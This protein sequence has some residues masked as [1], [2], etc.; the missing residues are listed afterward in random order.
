MDSVY[1]V[2]VKNGFIST[3]YNTERIT[4]PDS[5]TDD[6]SQTVTVVPNIIL[7]NKQLNNRW[8]E[9]DIDTLNLN[10]VFSV[11]EIKDIS[12]RKDNIST[13]VVIKGTQKNNII[14]GSLYNIDRD[15]IINS[16]STIFANYQPNKYIE[17]FVLENNVEIMRGKLLISSVNI[18][19]GIVYYNCSIIGTIYSF[20][21]N[22]N[23]FTLNELDYFSLEHRTL[24][25]DTIVDSDH[26]EFYPVIDYGGDMIS[27]YGTEVRYMGWDIDKHRWDALRPAINVNSYL[28][29]IFRGFRYDEVNKKYTQLDE[30]GLPIQLHKYSEN[31]LLRDLFQRLV[32]PN[33]DASFRKNTFGSEFSYQRKLVPGETT[34]YYTRYYSNNCLGLN[35][36]ISDINVNDKDNKGFT[37]LVANRPD[38]LF[39]TDYIN[40]GQLKFNNLKIHTAIST[41]YEMYNIIHIKGIIR[42]LNLLGDTTDLK[43]V[44]CKTTD[45]EFNTSNIVWEKQLNFFDNKAMID[46]YITIPKFEG[47]YAVALRSTKSNGKQYRANLYLAVELDPGIGANVP[48]MWDDTFTLQN[49]IPKNIKI[50][51]FLKH[52]MLLFNLYII[53]SD[54]DEQTYDFYTYPEFYKDV[55][56]LDTSTALDWSNKVD[57]SSYTINSNLELPKSYIFKYKEDSDLMNTLYKSLYNETY[58]QYNLI[59][60]AGL[61][62]PQTLESIFSPTI[63]LDWGSGRIIGMM[64]GGEGIGVGEKKQIK[65]NIRIAFVSHQTSCTPFYI[66]DDMAKIIRYEDTTV[67]VEF[68]N[69][70]YISMGRFL[71]SGGATALRTLCFGLPRQYWANDIIPFSLEDKTVYYRHFRTQIRELTD[72]NLVT[73]NLKVSLNEYDINNL[74]FRL[75]IF[76]RT[77]Y[78]S[79]YFKLLKVDYSNSNELSDVLLQKIV[80]PDT[81]LVE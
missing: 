18:K 24:N 62:D 71:P 13:D 69:Y 57:F 11:E 35:Y 7:T 75:P 23:D 39:Y 76:I 15:V 50:K 52:I 48:V 30:E 63:T 58:G 25:Y 19:S 47:D 64:C 4:A 45:G 26:M 9:L 27:K 60:S 61:T 77:P 22:L 5:E 21:S 72:P 67:D 12:K 20:F 53:K 79:A 42:E 3:E 44:I 55:L 33:N 74:N 17:C 32:I 10:S 37:P 36:V 70:R 8:E 6:V 59:N 31:S 46:E 49:G 66:T 54:D 28:D 14:L 40:I 51:D 56:K 80:L 81:N 65:T 38:Y 34:T 2:F 78:G 1:K 29:A 41:F 43:L 73:I 16:P 68:H